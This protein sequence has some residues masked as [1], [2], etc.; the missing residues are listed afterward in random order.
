MTIHP[1]S[2]AK[3]KGKFI[4]LVEPNSIGP[5]DVKTGIDHLKELGI[6]HV[7]LLPSFDHY[8]I[9][10]TNLNTPQYNW[11]YDPKNYNV[12]EGSYATDPYDAT[13]KI[14]EFKQMV[15]A[16]HDQGIGV[17]RMLFITI[18]EKRGNHYLIKRFQGIITVTTKMVV[19]QMRPRAA[20]K[21]HP[22][23]P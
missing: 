16:F 17:I 1:K 13:V 14:K 4:G 3:N 18:L 7:H 22:K 12:P 21:R 10:E 23:D 20:T 5:G 2:G 8:S 9:D 11:G 19:I 6:T 15:K